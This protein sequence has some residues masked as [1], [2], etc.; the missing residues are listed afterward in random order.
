MHSLRY[1]QITSHEPIQVI[2]VESTIRWLLMP[3][4]G[5]PDPDATFFDLTVGGVDISGEDEK[6]NVGLL[7]SK[8]VATVAKALQTQSWESLDKEAKAGTDIFPPGSW[9]VG[10]RP[11]FENLRDFFSVASEKGYAVLR[12]S[13]NW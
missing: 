5:R 9:H 6:Y 1:I 7:S 10:L 12:I 2:D 4:E 11:D 8:R 3:G 13:S